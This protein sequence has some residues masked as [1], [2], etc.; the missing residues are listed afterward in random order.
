MPHKRTHAHPHA[1][2]LCGPER[3]SA[4]PATLRANPPGR[5]RT[6]SRSRAH[7]PAPATDHSDPDAQTDTRAQSPTHAPPHARH[8]L[9]HTQAHRARTRGPS[10]RPPAAPVGAGSAGGGSCDTAREAERGWAAPATSSSSSGSKPAEPGQG[11]AEGSEGAGGAGH[12]AMAH[13]TGIHGEGGRRAGA[14]RGVFAR[15]CAPSPA[16]GPCLLPGTSPGKLPV[17]FCSCRSPWGAP[18]G[19]GGGLTVQSWEWVSICVHISGGSICM[20]IWVWMCLCDYLWILFLSGGG[21]TR[22]HTSGEVCTHVHLCVQSCVC[23]SGA[24]AL[25]AG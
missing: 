7:E 13:Q 5:G 11:R 3:E 17:L 19:A 16:P 8:L 18:L 2:P 20:P 1:D 22:M 15:G 9:R 14:G 12:G 23:S 21:C 10:P 6:D 24:H 25:L 4:R